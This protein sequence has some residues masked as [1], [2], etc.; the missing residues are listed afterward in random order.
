MAGSRRLIRDYGQELR[1]FRGTG[2]KARVVAIAAAYLWLPTT[3]DDEWAGILTIAGITAIGALGLNL[4]TGY[5]GQ[6]SLGSAAFIGIGAFTAGYLG[7]RVDVFGVLERDWP[8]LG[9][10]AV[11]AVIGGLIGLIVGLPALRLRGNYLIIVTLGLVF[12]GLYVFQSWEEV[13]G[14]NAGSPMPIDVDVFGLNFTALDVFGREFARNQSLFYLVWLIVAIVGVLLANLV[15][16]RPGRA[17]QAVR[18]RD[19]A[20]EVVG[21]S[22]FKYKLVAFVLSSAIISMAGV[23]YGIYLQYLT[24]NESSLGLSVSISYLAIVIIGGI[25][26]TYGPVLGALVVALIPK[27]VDLVATDL[28]FV[29]TKAS[30]SGINKDQL[31]IVLQALLIIVA[32]VTEPNGLAGLLRRVK[33]YFAS[34]PL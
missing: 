21:V 10:L 27:L 26:T 7:G 25:G 14:G 11:A 4:L 19:V 1:L 30:E 8:F 6:P 20:A 3:L 32:L 2:R 13:T 18:D 12:V 29:A 16:S 23:L 15:R 31:V 9:Y 24:P 28:P 17:L 34:W 22:L 33:A 5:T